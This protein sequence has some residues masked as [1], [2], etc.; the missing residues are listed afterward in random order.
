MMEEMREKCKIIFKKISNLKLEGHFK[1]TLDT[2]S[3]GSDE[4]N[5]VG[6]RKGSLH[7]P[8]NRH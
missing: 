6:S 7:F 1:L 2:A 4:K 3:L 8:N 5:Y